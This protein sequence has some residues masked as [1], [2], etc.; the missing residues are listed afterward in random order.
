M[1]KFP[2]K[3]VHSKYICITASIVWSIPEKTQ[4]QRNPIS[5]FIDLY[6]AIGLGIYWHNRVSPANLL[7][8]FLLYC[9]RKFTRWLPVQNIYKSNAYNNMHN[10]VPIVIT[11]CIPTYI[12]HSIASHWRALKHNIKYI[13][14][15]VFAAEYFSPVNR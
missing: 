12:I 1:F 13:I 4:M 5:N 14:I 6:Y 9:E 2:Q 8:T 15:R 11:S 3:S 7:K 10:I